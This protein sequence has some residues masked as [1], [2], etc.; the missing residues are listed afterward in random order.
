MY[1]AVPGCGLATAGRFSLP[2]GA[3]RAVSGLNRH[4]WLNLAAG[5][6]L[7]YLGTWQ[8]DDVERDLAASVGFSL[9][10][11]SLKKDNS[12]LANWLLFDC[13]ERS[14]KSGTFA[15]S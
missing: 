15:G 13:H 11:Q 9:P 14:D 8:L 3:G 1:P 7:Q 2:A 6:V 4:G 10:L 5:N 12:A